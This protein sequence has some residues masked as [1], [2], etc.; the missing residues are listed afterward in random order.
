MTDEYPKNLA[1]FEQM[2][3]TEDACRE[4]L[5]H[6]RWP[7]GFVCPRC[8]GRKSWSTER[9][10]LVCT[11][12]GHQASLTAGTLFQDTRKTLIWCGFAPCGG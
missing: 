9:D 2:F 4:Y 3:A 7:A 8:Q 5:F 11:A 6:L 1:D 10:L 12:C